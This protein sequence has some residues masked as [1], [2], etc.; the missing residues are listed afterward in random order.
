VK[1]LITGGLGYIGSHLVQFLSDNLGYQ[2]RILDLNIPP[3]FK[4]WESKYE[5]IQGDITKKDEISQC[6]LDCDAV[7]LLAALDKTEARLDPE[8]ALKVSGIGTRNILEEVAE[9]NVQKIIYFST[10]HV[11]GVPGKEKIDEN[12][13][14]NPL[15]DYSIAHYAGE[16]YCQQFRELFNLNTIR[17]RFSNGYGAPVKKSINC[18]SIVVHDFCQ[19]AF[20][21]RK[22][23]LKSEGTQKRDF[24][25]I[26]DI[27][28]SIQL[29]LK[30]DRSKIKYDLYNVGSGV[31]FSIKEIAYLVK[32]TYEE[33]YSEKIKIEFAQDLI[34]ADFKNPF[35]LDINR[36]KELGFFPKG[37]E[38]MKEEI[39]KIFAL[40]EE[41]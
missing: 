40:L 22:V 41:G 32:E 6:C 26:P 12:T 27:L 7:L 19:A 16:L 38:I 36:I 39:K 4:D 30:A 34:P 9:Y 3:E 5:I 15:N 24:I 25:S 29:L 35:V 33:V 8:L 37:P 18:W 2:V 21:Q 23:I 28:Q 10:I 20:Q 11:Y 31:S 14:V 17:I 1:I 13:S